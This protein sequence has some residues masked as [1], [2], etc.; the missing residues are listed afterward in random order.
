MS[1][2]VASKCWLLATVFLSS[3]VCVCCEST[4]ACVRE[5]RWANMLRVC[6]T[7]ERVGL[8]L[9]YVRWFVNYAVLSSCLVILR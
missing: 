5:T 7:I 2:M 6:A 3:R 9:A 4:R 8:L 1:G